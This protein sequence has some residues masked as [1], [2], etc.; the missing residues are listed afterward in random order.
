MDFRLAP[1][2]LLPA[3]AL[4]SAAMC[5]FLTGCGSN[6]TFDVS[7]ES[8]GVPL[9]GMLHG[10]QSPI[11]GAS[12]YLMAANTTG[13]GASSVSLLKSGSGPDANGDYYVVTDSNGNFNISGDYTC[14]SG[15]QVYV[16][17][18]GGNPGLTTGTNNS[19]IRQ[20]ALLG[21]CP[22]SGTFVGTVSYIYIDE[23]STVAAAYS[24]AG[25]A[26]DSLHVSSSGTAAAKAGVANAFAT[27]ASLVSLA[28]GSAYATTPA[29]TGYAG[30]LSANGTVPQ[31][32]INT[33]ANILAMCVN[34]SSPTSSQCAALFADA[35]SVTGT[36][37]TNVADAAIYL[38]HNPNAN[39]NVTALYNIMTG[40]QPFSPY[41]SAAPNDWTLQIT[42]STPTT[43][44]PGRIAIDGSGNV[45]IPD[46]TKNTI[47]ELSPAG[48]VLS[49]T[50]GYTHGVDHPISVGVDAH[51]NI[52]CVDD[53]DSN[54]S[55]FSSSGA[56]STQI[57]T[58]SD[59]NYGVAFDSNGYIWVSGN[60][61]ILAFSSTGTSEASFTGT[62]EE[63]SV[64]TD[65]SG[66]IWSV[67]YGSNSLVHYTSTTSDT[68]Y[69]VNLKTPSSLAIDSSGNVWI[70]NYGNNSLGKF[71]TSTHVYSTVS[72]GGIDEPIGVAVDGLGYIFVGNYNG[73]ISEV[74]SS[75][76]AVS[77]TN[78]F[79]TAAY[80]LWT[81]NEN[82]M[83]ASIFPAYGI[84]GVS[85]DGS[86]NLW[87]SD[88]DGGI[89]E[90]VGLANPVVT[91]LTYTKLGV[92]P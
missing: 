11:S 47:T 80:K 67:S 77:G 76:T 62:V 26:T 64:A 90:F 12:I 3:C 86:G 48:A 2:R 63:A 38:A 78:G 70:S 7:E 6:P 49:G 88:L 17:A 41:L 31:Q 58:G 73:T 61:G 19:A 9:Q 22:A 91:P 69:A 65:S 87:T 44:N 14:T 10:G 24:L 66:T 37:A 60:G 42:Y 53:S 82:A 45:W 23:V 56:A 46:Y 13:Y 57:N 43:A 84:F 39:G 92:R 68:T 85:V 5:P 35:K 51:G 71:I 55:E 20:M 83:F 32:N 33:L 30:S 52:W 36:Q 28:S 29:I 50:A 89:Y 8:Q 4:L 18:E 1:V 74:N 34:T 54:L 79:E 25:F 16:L 40:T 72:V 21:S 81:G 75:G 59:T 27:S 15:Q